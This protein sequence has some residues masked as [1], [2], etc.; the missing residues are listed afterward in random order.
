MIRAS[1][2]KAALSYLCEEFYDRPS[3]KLKIIGI[4]GTNGK[5]ST[6]NFYTQICKYAG[7]NSCSLGS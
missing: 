3:H 1:D 4:T 6:V 7:F 5:T 2:S